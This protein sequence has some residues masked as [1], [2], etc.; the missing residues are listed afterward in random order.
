MGFIS[1]IGAAF[2][3]SVVSNQDL[4]RFMETSDDWI[5]QRSGISTRHWARRGFESKGETSN[6]QMALEAS[7]IALNRAALSAN[8]IDGIVYATI[9]SDLEFPGNGAA[10]QQ[11]L[12]IKRA[13]PV[14]EVRNHCSGFLYALKVANTYLNRGDFRHILVLGLELQS[15]GLNLCN[16][17]R[18]TAVLFGDGGGALILSSGPDQSRG[19]LEVLLESDGSF[20]DKLGIEAPGF[21]RSCYILPEDFDGD[22]APAYPRMDGKL[23]FKMASHKMP[24]IVRKT[25]KLR[26]LSVSDL[27][28]IIPHQANQRIIDMLT[29]ELKPSCPVYSNIARFGN[30]T[31]GSIPLALNECVEQGLLKPGMLVCLVTFGAGFSWGAAL[32]RW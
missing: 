2:P 4:T 26:G 27:D 14:F 15:T 11:A 3:K 6:L 30:T 5:V 28:L 29:H 8:D 18:N 24:E 7:K 13:I 25:L 1:A 19:I 21:A 16:S 20:A 22:N 17:G 32:I 23:V 10:L 31:A 9:T 12:G